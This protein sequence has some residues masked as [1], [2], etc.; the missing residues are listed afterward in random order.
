MTH[1]NRSASPRALALVIAMLNCTLPAF[2]SA[3]AAMLMDA[4]RQTCSNVDET[5]KRCISYNVPKSSGSG[6]AWG[7]PY[8]LKAD[9]PPT[10]YK[11]SAETFEL[12]GPHKCIGNDQNPMVNGGWSTCRLV[13]RKDD[14]V[15]W[16][17]DIQ[18]IQGQED[19]SVATTNPQGLPKEVL[20]WNQ[21]QDKNLSET[22][23]LIL[24]YVKIK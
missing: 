7:G 4:T 10:G 21:G 23:I 18:G 19:L 20:A 12:L 5:H 13:Y 1:A 14:E 9:A 6:A 11:L 15:L 2:H 24:D 3:H 8:Y 17:Y 22:A 16:E